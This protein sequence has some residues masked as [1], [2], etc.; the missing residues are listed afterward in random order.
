MKEE[1][2]TKKLCL[3]YYLLSTLYAFYGMISLYYLII[4]S[5]FADEKIV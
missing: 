3:Y 2:K 1:K 5:I 4:I